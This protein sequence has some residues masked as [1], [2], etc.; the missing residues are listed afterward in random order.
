M[1]YLI[2]S[3]LLRTTFLAGAFDT[4]ILHNKWLFR[5]IHLDETKAFLTEEEN[6]FVKEHIPATLLFAEDDIALNEVINNKNKYMIK[7]MDAYASKGVYAPGPEYT[8]DEWEEVCKKLYN[9]NYICQEY[10]EQYTSLNIDIAWGDGVLK[11][12]IN[13]PGLY[14]YNGKFSGILMRTAPSGEIIYAHENERTLPVY[15]LEP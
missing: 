13:M 6:K 2:S 9:D 14:M 4:Q 15:V 5:V 1:K 11:E 12:Y 7:P 3:G 8:V 10:C